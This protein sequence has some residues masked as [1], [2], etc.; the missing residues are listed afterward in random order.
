[1]N[2]RDKDLIIDLGEGRLTQAETEAAMSR[3]ANDPEFA[4]AY[5]QQM[6]VR[7]TLTDQQEPMMSGAER[8][9]MR[10]KLVE[11][12]HLEDKPVR[13]KPGPAK[14]P[15]W[16]PVLGLTTVAAAV[17]AIALLPG[18]LGSSSDEG[19]TADVRFNATDGAESLPPAAG[20]EQDAGD[21]AVDLFAPG[22]P[23]EVV[24]LP[25]A[26]VE[27]L[28]EATEGNTTPAEVERNMSALGYS[29]SQFVDGSVIEDCVNAI[30]SSLPAGTTSV[31][32]LG[33][34]STGDSTIVHLG[35]TMNAGIEA[36]VTI[37][38]SDCSILPHDS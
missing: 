6:A 36:V 20:M 30:R 34:D 3:V 16:Q 26:K 29:K 13:S 24:D 8:S 14:R 1:M 28:L 12:L 5:R 33:A 17:V 11:E 4:A 38:L 9:A 21:D 10:A 25:D 2:D 27:E 7:D 32:V 19:G 31:L 18:T 15:W 22:E 35:L 37:D 23:V